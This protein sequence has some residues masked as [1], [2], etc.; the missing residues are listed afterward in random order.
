MKRNRSLMWLHGSA[1]L[2]SF[3]NSAYLY[4]YQALCVCRNGILN[5]C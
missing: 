5:G 2:E 1:D 3:G 4:A